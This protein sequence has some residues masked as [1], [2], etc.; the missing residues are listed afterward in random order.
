MSRLVATDAR[1]VELLERENDFLRGQIV[2]TDDQIKDLT[3]RSR[4]SAQP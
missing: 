2:T 4:H 3:E 1:I